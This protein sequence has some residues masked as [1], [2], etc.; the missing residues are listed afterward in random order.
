M[1]DAQELRPLTGRLFG[2][3][4]TCRMLGISRSTLTQWIEKE[5]IVPA[6]QLVERGAYVFTYGEIQRAAK[7][8][9]REL[10]S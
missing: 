7:E 10:A 4:E 5:W 2:S 3:T 8:Q 6:D 9:A 1:T